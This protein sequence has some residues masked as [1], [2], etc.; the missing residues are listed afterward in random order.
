MMLS[1]REEHSFTDNW[2][3]ES[4]DQ[5]LYQSQYVNCSLLTVVC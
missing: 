3:Q 2:F 4:F 5:Q 1:Q